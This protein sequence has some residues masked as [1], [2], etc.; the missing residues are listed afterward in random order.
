MNWSPAP[1]SAPKRA[2]RIIIYSGPPGINNGIDTSHP[3]ASG[4]AENLLSRLLSS[5]TA[6]RGPARPRRHPESV[7]WGKK[8]PH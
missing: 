2:T 6:P 7:N 1:V 8:S 3:F 5:R 4:K